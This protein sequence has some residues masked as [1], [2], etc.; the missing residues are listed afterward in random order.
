MVRKVEISSKTITFTVFF[1]LSLWFLYQVRSI[2][3]M[4]FVSFILMTAITPIVRLAGKIKIPTFVTVFVLYILIISSI[5]GIIASLIPAV[6]YQT[7]GLIN[8][9]P[10][11]TQSFSQNFNLSL[12]PSLLM[13]Q[14]S[15]V[16]SNLLKIAAGAFSNIISILAVFFI[17]YYLILERPNLHNY[18]VKFFGNNN[19]EKKAEQFVEDLETKLGGWIRGELALMLIIGISTYF[20]LYLLNIPYALPLA[21]LAGVLEIIPNIG[22]TLAAVP[23]IFIGL[24]VSPLTALGVLALNILIQQLENNLI[25]PKVMQKAIGVKPLVTIVVLFTGFT[26]AGILGAVLA[27]PVYLTV[28]IITKYM[29]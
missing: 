11:L 8:Q 10:Q 4:L 17:T 16:P 14:F 24:T 9:L 18:L 2:I 15:S 1:L 28:T 7:R 22:P 5:T 23:A 12:D 29:D 6:I 20:G 27:M 19:A 21:L 13:N 3:V 26:L 25:V